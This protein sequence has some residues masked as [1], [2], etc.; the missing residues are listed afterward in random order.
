MQDK[1]DRPQ[2]F[3][4][5]FKHTYKYWSKLNKKIQSKID[6]K[7]L[8]NDKPYKPTWCELIVI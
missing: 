2:P 1:D 6:P 7:Y 8:V 3:T 4:N 5:K